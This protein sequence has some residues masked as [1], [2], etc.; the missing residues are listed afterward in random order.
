MVSFILVLLK[1][2]PLRHLHLSARVM[3]STIRKDAGGQLLCSS[4]NSLPQLQLE[5]TT[6]ITPVQ[7]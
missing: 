6:E 3:P 1:N 5:G 2:D 4:C 7:K